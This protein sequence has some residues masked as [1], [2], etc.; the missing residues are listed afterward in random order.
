MCARRRSN[1][2][3]RRQE[4]VTKEKATPLPVSPLAWRRLGQP[5]MLEAG[6]R[7][8]T[9]C[10]PPSGELRSDICGESDDEA[11]VS[12]GT[13]ATPASAL[14][15]TVRRGGNGLHTGHCFA[16]PV[17]LRCARLA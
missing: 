13:R 10:V 11:R 4:K 7:L 5:A 17:V 8:A 3:L 9:H 1:F 2:L 12:F 16:R 15:S 14:L 6:V